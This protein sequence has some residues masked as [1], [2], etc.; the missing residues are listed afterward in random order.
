[1]INFS[2]NNADSKNFTKKSSL[3]SLGGLQGI[4]ST[5]I[6][7]HNQSE[8]CLSYRIGANIEVI[9][10]NIRRINDICI[11]INVYSATSKEQSIGITGTVLR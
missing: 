6:F 2:S 7:T 8:L 3:L 4:D 10:Q 1:M 11:G 5:S 9:E